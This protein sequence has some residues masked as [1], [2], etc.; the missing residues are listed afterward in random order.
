MCKYMLWATT[1]SSFT[2][3]ILNPIFF[4]TVLKPLTEESR[5]KLQSNEN[6]ID[7]IKTVK[8]P[9]DYKIVP[10]DLKSPFT[11]IPLALTLD[12]T[13]TAINNSTINLSLP[14]DDLMHLLNLFLTFRTMA[15][16]KNSCMEQLW[17]HQFPLSQKSFCKTSRSPR[18]S[19][20]NTTTPTTLRWRY[21]YS[22]TQRR[23]RRFSRTPQQTK[24]W[25]TCT[26]Y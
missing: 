26:V 8:E 18:N 22:C 23:N 7:A 2:D 20:T 14:T 19:E 3:H 15:S 21:L 4:T 11:S 24:R 13:E 17:V 25:H 6:C 5:H 9:D 1:L 16:T 10:F 12:C